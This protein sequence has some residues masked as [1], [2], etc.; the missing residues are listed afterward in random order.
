VHQLVDYDHERGISQWTKNYR[1]GIER[2]D[3]EALTR[4]YSYYDPI[5]TLPAAGQAW[6]REHAED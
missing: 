6:W 5:D 2:S 1:T 4:R 3:A